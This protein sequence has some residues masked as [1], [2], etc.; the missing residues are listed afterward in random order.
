M[1][2]SWQ[3]YKRQVNLSINGLLFPYLPIFKIFMIFAYHHIQF[4]ISH[5]GDLRTEVWSPNPHQNTGWK[6]WYSIG[7]NILIVNWSN[8]FC[9]MVKMSGIWIFGLII[10]TNYLKTG[11]KVTEN[12]NVGISVHLYTDCYCTWII[13]KLLNLI[14]KG[15]KFILKWSNL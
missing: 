3:I 8:F 13:C 4:S 7:T 6:V 5:S 10:W 15:L 11:Q 12:P 14:E 2:P 1:D 9:F